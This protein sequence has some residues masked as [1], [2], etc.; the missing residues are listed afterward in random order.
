MIHPSLW[1][2]SAKHLSELNGKI[3]SLTVTCS[4]LAGELAAQQQQLL[5]S[6]KSKSQSNKSPW[7][8]P[9]ATLIAALIAALG[10]IYSG[11]NTSQTNAALTRLTTLQSENAKKDLQ[12]YYA[13]QGKIAKL[14]QGFETFLVEKQLSRPNNA[15]ELGNDL[16]GMCI[17]QRF[18]P[19]T[20]IVKEYNDF[21][22]EMISALERNP[23]RWKD[24]DAVREEAKGKCKKAIEAL[25]DLEQNK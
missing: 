5:D 9:A 10:A 11:W 18:G 20:P 16:D 23:Q 14:E 6:V 4:G 24:I 12:T 15:H 8:V 17:A 21:I 13:T 1:K 7:M 19:K 25:D 2:R 22:F 3:E